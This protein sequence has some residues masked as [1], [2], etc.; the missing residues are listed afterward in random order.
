MNFNSIF[1]NTFTIEKSSYNKIAGNAQEVVVYGFEHCKYKDVARALKNTV[2][3]V[4]K[5]DDFDKTFDERNVKNITL[6]TDA[7]DLFQSVFKS[8]LTDGTKA[9]FAGRCKET[10]LNLC[11]EN[12]KR[13]LEGRPIIPLIY[14]VDIE[15]NPY[16]FE[17]KNIASEDKLLNN[18]ITHKEL[19]LCYK[20]VN[21]FGNS[22][23]SDVFK[24]TLKFVKLTDNGN[25]EYKLEEIQ[26]FWENSD[27]SSVWNARNK[28]T[29]APVSNW[30][31]K[32][33]HQIKMADKKAI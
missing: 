4:G 19:R 29:H 21:E 7:K 13:S 2:W 10:L 14:C 33:N 18:L 15:K 27:W 6:K 17:A 9:W 5:W 30:R 24:N 26:P 20:I 22:K 31:E 32:L 25:S 16:S 3:K 23:I 8:G 1:N 11:V 28:R 12:Y